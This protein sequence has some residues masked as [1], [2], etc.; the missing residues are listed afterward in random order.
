M[1]SRDSARNAN[2][3]LRLANKS[4]VIKIKPI[5]QDKHFM[6]LNVYTARERWKQNVSLELSYTEQQY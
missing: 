3:Q 1:Y 2:L 5:S 4:L 6:K